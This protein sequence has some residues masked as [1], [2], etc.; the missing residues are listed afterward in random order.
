V[1]TTATVSAALMTRRLTGSAGGRPG[2]W[3]AWATA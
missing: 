3:G 2:Q 1:P